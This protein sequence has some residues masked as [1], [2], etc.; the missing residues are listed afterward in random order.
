MEKYTEKQIERLKNV[1][2]TKTFGVDNE[3]FVRFLEC[4]DNYP[5][6]VI[7]VGKTYPNKNYYVYREK[8]NISVMEYVNGGE[9]Y[10]IINDKKIKV[11]E[12]DF[13]YLRSG[14]QHNYYADKKNPYTKTWMNFNSSIIDALAE[15]IGV[16]ETTVIR[17]TDVSAYFEA[18]IETASSGATSLSRVNVI[19][20]LVV[21]ILLRAG[22]ELNMESS[23]SL[24]DKIKELLD[25]SVYS[26]KNINEISDELKFSRQHVSKH[27]SDKFGISPLKYLSDK[28]IDAAKRALKYTD[29]PVKK[30]CAMLGFSSQQYFALVFRRKTGLKPMQYRRKY[31]S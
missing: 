3:E 10:V 14:E 18:L 29:V 12:G 31:K 27:F 7:M 5:I 4:K 20:Q 17:C 19:F 26:S 15:K 11:K 21:S 8:S 9:G 22:D 30:I 28:K 16:S 1:G 25:C 23:Y 6:E 24:A 13:I 2:R